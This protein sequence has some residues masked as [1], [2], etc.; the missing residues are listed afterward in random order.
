MNPFPFD[1]VTIHEEGD[2]RTL[3]LSEFLAS[4]LPQRIQ[5]ILERR[6]EFFLGS[7]PSSGG[8]RCKHCGQ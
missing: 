1:H 7:E 5:L 6:V 3:T 2:D 4:P 8:R